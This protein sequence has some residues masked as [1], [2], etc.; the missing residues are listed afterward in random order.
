LTRR[1]VENRRGGGVAGGEFF[2]D[3]GVSHGV[4]PIGCGWLT[5]V[6]VLREL[7]RAAASRLRARCKRTRAADSLHLRTSA[8]SLVVKCS[9]AA[10]RRTS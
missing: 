5:R 9:Q 4:S 8:S 1:L 10:S 3:V 7:S 6:G 2:C